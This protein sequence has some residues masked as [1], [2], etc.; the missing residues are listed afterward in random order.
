MHGVRGAGPLW[1]SVLF[2][3]MLSAACTAVADV[4]YQ[5]LHRQLLIDVRDHQVL[6]VFTAPSGSPSEEKLRLLTAATG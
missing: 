1:R 3:V 2:L 6:M 5:P 4:T